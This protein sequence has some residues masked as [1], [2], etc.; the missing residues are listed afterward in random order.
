MPSTTL[1]LYNCLFAPTSKLLDNA[2]D[3]NSYVSYTKKKRT[4]II[5][6]L[7]FAKNQCTDCNTKET[8]NLSDIVHPEL[9]AAKTFLNQHSTINRPDNVLEEDLLC[10]DHTPNVIRDN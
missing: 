3:G 4:I 6:E 8:L 2:S 7:S 1:I 10:V 5:N 9:D